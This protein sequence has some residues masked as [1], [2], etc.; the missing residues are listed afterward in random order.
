M[1][2]LPPGVT[3]Q[4]AGS[5]DRRRVVL[6]VE[7]TSFHFRPDEARQVGVMLIEA[8]ASDFDPAESDFNSSASTEEE[9][10]P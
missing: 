10:P 4:I 7:E 9:V 1:A 3:V 5:G 6:E 2:D 8:A